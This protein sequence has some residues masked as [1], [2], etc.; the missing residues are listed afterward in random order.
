MYHRSKRLLIE[1]R[2]SFTT[3]FLKYAD[4]LS[5]ALKHL[6]SKWQNQDHKPYLFIG[7]QKLGA[8]A[9]PEMVK[10]LEEN[11]HLVNNISTHKDT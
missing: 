3:H 2:R 10:Q 4:F 11:K 1:Y 8:K 5:S 9:L 6:T 7:F